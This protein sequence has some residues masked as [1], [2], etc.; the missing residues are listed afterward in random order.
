[1]TNGV[2]NMIETEDFFFKCPKTQITIRKD[3]ILIIDG[4]GNQWVLD[5]KAVLE[6][7]VK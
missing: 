4:T 7:L 1:M 5:K 2:E 6:E 3:T